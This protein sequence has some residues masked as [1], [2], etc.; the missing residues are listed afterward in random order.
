MNLRKLSFDNISLEQLYSKVY[1]TSPSDCFSGYSLRQIEDQLPDK[2][3]RNKKYYACLKEFSDK[4]YRHF[5]MFADAIHRCKQRHTCRTN[6]IGDP[7]GRACD[8][9]RGYCE[10]HKIKG[11]SDGKLN[12]LKK[13]FLLISR[14]GQLASWGTYPLKDFKLTPD[15]TLA[16]VKD[17]VSSNSS[18]VGFVKAMKTREVNQTWSV[19]LL[20]RFIE[21]EGG[22][23]A[24]RA[25]AKEADLLECLFQLVNNQK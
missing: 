17:L 12:P 15:M 23:S 19:D 24:S 1:G 4:S 14:K 3:W 8:E 25:K 13:H 16:Q 2:K 6:T 10:L 5:L 9:I 7:L 18:L 20:K 22:Q 11:P 21:L